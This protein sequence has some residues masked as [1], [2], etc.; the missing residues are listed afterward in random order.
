M[1]E[2]KSLSEVKKYFGLPEKTEKQ[3]LLDEL[4]YGYITESEYHVQLG[5]LM[6]R[7]TMARIRSIN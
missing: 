4:R 3:K 1:R 7:Q 6:A 2:F 5:A